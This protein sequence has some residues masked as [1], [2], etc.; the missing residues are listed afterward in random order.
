MFSTTHRFR[1]VGPAPSS[2]VEVGDAK[3]SCS[4]TGLILK[5]AASLPG[6]AASLPG[7][8]E[9]LRVVLLRE[10]DEFLPYGLR[11][12]VLTPPLELERPARAR[13][14]DMPAPALRGC[15]G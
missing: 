7:I 6:T 10:A 2:L 5:S 12:R 13:E 8:C 1:G 3:L 11:H 9:A 4:F 15:Y 14:H